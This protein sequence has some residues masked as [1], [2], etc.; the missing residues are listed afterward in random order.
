[1]M[2][3]SCEVECGR[4]QQRRAEDYGHRGSKG[5]CAFNCG[6]TIAHAWAIASKIVACQSYVVLNKVMVQLAGPRQY[7][8]LRLGW[9]RGSIANRV[10]LVEFAPLE[11]HPPHTSGLNSLCG[12]RNL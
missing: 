2:A 5:H 3:H 12:Q 1:M 7:C 10:S 11:C 9:L 8:R 4:L 6:P